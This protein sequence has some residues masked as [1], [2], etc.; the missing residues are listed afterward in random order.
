MVKI[1][2][3]ITFHCFSAGKDA[4]SEVTNS[5]VI[6]LFELLREPGSV[7]RNELSKIAETFGPCDRSLV[8]KAHKL[9]QLL[10]SNIPE[11]ELNRKLQRSTKYENG[12]GFGGEIKFSFPEPM[13]FEDDLTLFDTELEDEKPKFSLKF[14]TESSTATTKNVPQENR[15]N[16]ASP[17]NVNELGDVNWLRQRCDFYFGSAGENLNSADMCSVIFDLLSSPRG[18]QE[19]QNEL[20]ELLGFD[21]FE[22]I[23]EL[24]ANREKVVTGGGK[25]AASVNGNKSKS[26]LNHNFFCLMKTLYKTTYCMLMLTRPKKIPVVPV[27][28]P[29]L[30]FSADPIIFST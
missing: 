15:E 21:R 16:C 9:T 17:T 28:R 8:E 10:L 14:T 25:K 27:T 26:L 30:I 6:F 29:T 2:S 11:D 3:S 1:I 5:T 13:E 19:M 22:F 4:S 18:D 20:F 23:E 12:P 7:S 24:L